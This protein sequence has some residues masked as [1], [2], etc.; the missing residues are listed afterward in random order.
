MAPHGEWNWKCDTASTDRL[1]RVTLTVW[2][3]SLPLLT[4]APVTTSIRRT[5][6]CLSKV[7]TSQSE[8]RNKSVSADPL[9]AVT[10]TIKRVLHRYVL[11]RC[12][13]ND[14]WPLTFDLWDSNSVQIL[15]SWTCHRVW[16]AKSDKSSFGCSTTCERTH[17]HTHTYTNSRT[18]R[19]RER[20]RERERRQDKI[21]N[22]GGAVAL[23]WTLLYAADTGRH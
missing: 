18:H 17:T 19:E 12:L 23:M 3:D 11:N 13:P 8:W 10:L 2:T 6:D 22:S 4:H 20:E 14:L 7:V 5:F 1:Y 9:T 21:A 15:G 16:A